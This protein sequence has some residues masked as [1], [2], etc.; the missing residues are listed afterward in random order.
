MPEPRGT[1]AFEELGLGTVLKRYRLKVPANQREYAW[2]EKEVRQLLQDFAREVLRDTS[3]FLGTVVTI[4]RQGEVLEVVDGQQ[5]LATTVLLLAAIRDY[6]RGRDDFLVGSIDDDFLAHRDRTSRAL[7]PKLTLNV[8]DNELFTRLI[9]NEADSAPSTPL[10]ASLKRLVAAQKE[11]RKQVERIVAPH[12]ARKHGDVLNEW[13]SFV[14]NQALVILLKVPTESDAFKMFETL[15]DRG[16]KT[17]QA[18]LVKNYL[19]EKAA[20]RIQEVQG[21]WSYMRGALESASDDA[22][23]TITFLRHALI[24]QKGHLREADVYDRVRDIAQSAP[25]AVTFA[26]TLESLANTYVA[27]FNPEHERW[28]A[29]PDAGRRAIE[30]LNL[31]DIKPMR[32]LILAVAARMEPRE[33]SI[34]L[35]FLIA[36][37][38]RLMIASST[39]SSSVEVPLAEAARAVFDPAPEDEQVTTAEQLAK[40]LANLIPSDADFRLAF[41]DAKVSTARLAR[42][43]LRSLE[44]ASKGESEPWFVPHD[45]KQIINLE[46]VLPRKPEGNWPQF[47]DEEVQLYATRLGNLALMRASDNSDLKSCAFSDKKPLYAASPY[48]LT[49]MIGEADDW[50]A[51]T[52]GSRQKQLADIAVSTWPAT[53]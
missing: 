50:T 42:Y 26:L 20:D 2:T 32:P 41:A 49:S 7:V 27:S 14:E 52:I 4:P 23:T 51:E 40:R 38:V 46:H 9:T 28:N 16:L 35:Q 36:L 47:T 34:A 10:R 30:A 19:F 25:S 1:I 43:Y 37:G 45:D 33:A 11:A 31:I 22:D 18:D 44:M 6:L 21:S 24:V 15:N 13:L 17:S 8:D 48:S 53:P 39:R 12:D 29:Y 5:R 3:Y